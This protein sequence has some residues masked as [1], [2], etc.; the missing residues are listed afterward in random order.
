MSFTKNAAFEFVT[1]SQPALQ[2]RCLKPDPI[3]AGASAYTFQNHIQMEVVTPRKRHTGCFRARHFLTV[4]LTE[5]KV[6]LAPFAFRRKR[7]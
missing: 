5:K 4:E 6:I 2:I 1:N 3:L 7:T